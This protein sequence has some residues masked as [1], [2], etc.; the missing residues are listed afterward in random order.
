VASTKSARRRTHR[1]LRVEDKKFF[2]VIFFFFFLFF[3]LLVV[4]TAPARGFKEEEAFS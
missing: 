3:F 4:Y 2:F 1:V